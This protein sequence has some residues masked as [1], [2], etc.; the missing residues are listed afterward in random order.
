VSGTAADNGGGQVAG[1]EV[2]TDGGTTWHPATG[3]TSWT[4]AWN[5]QTNGP[6]TVKSR[7]VD[8]SGNLETPSAGIN[9]SVTCPCQLFPNVAVPIRDDSGDG[10]AVEVGVKFR[11]TTDGWITGVRFY[12]SSANTGTHIGD[13]WSSTGQ[14]LAR[15][16]FSGE[17]A[18]GWQQL[19]FPTAVHISP[20]TTYVGAY[21]TNTGHYA[22]DPGGF[23]G[24]N[25]A[26]PPL[27]G[28]QNSTDTS[29][30]T[31]VDGPNGVFAYGAT[32]IFPASG[33]NGNN[34][35]TDV[36]FRPSSGPPFV[37]DQSPPANGTNAS[38]LTPIK[39]RLSTAVTPSSISFTLSDP[40]HN[41]MAGTVTYDAVS[42]V[43]AFTPGSAL[44]QGTTYTATVS[45]ATNAQGQAMT[46]PAMWSFTTFSCPCSLWSSSV[47]PTL[48]DSNDANAVELGTRFTSDFNGT[49]SGLRFYKTPA[50]TGTHIGSLWAA[51]GTLLAQATAQGET[52]SG[53]QTITF[54]TPVAVTAG[55]PYL[56]SYHTDAGHYSAEN[57]YFATM[58]VDSGP[59]HAPADTATAP[60]GIFQYTTSPVFPNSTFKSTNY[61]VD[62]IFAT[63]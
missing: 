52:A 28:L 55:T 36:V 46:A 53:W 17:S 6:V 1:V 13:L 56:V 60:N 5:V 8:D 14:L 19:T 21:H 59:L 42:S 62:P 57:S 40:S 25:V 4:Y 35:W 48:V 32:P 37:V 2:S 18:N 12:K 23:S 20:N 43:V 22:F 9:V 24:R 47:T 26:S 27:I 61:W 50:N 15:G 63:N 29:A 16:T 58:G 38:T 49:V 45:G 3:T 30:T 44:A 7:A 33:F 11:S 10:N 54:T 41:P 34:Y 51:D 39:A 31:N